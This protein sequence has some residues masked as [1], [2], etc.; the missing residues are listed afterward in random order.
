M[1]ELYEY[2]DSWNG[3]T[4][5]IYIVIVFAIVIMFYKTKI[6]NNVYIGIFLAIFVIS[7]LNNRAIVA[8]DTDSDIKKIKKDSIQPKLNDEAITHEN[9]LSMIFSIQDIYAYNPQQYEIMIKSINNFYELYKL[10]FIDNSTVFVNYGMMEQYKRDALNA[11]KSMIF[12]LPI[13]RDILSKINVSAIA[14]D[15]I[16]TRD[17]DQISYL[18]DNRIYKHGYDIDTKI[19]TNGPKPFNTYDDMFRNFSYEVC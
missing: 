11:L 2:I 4:L 3:Q 5:F 14:L 15:D 17:L 12:S 7:Y 10:S 6:Q 19:I 13:D 16:M 18:T 8:A 9:L 1:G